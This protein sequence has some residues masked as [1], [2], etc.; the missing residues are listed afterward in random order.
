MKIVNYNPVQIEQEI[1]RNRLSIPKLLR[2]NLV[3]IMMAMFTT[4]FFAIVG[5]LASELSQ[6]NIV[7]TE[8][9]KIVSIATLFIGLAL[10]VAYAFVNRNTYSE[11]FREWFHKHISCGKIVGVRRENFES[12]SCL[13]VSFENTDGTVKTIVSPP[14]SVSEH[15]NISDNFLDLSTGRLKICFEQH[16]ALDLGRPT[17]EE[18]VNENH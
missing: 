6:F 5:F 3:N 18:N 8:I 4:T 1:A 11:D 12:V 17:M 16:L 9:F 10:L 7:V 14:V 2:R 15:T 13:K